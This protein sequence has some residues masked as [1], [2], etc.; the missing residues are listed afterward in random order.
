MS[1]RDKDIYPGGKPPNIERKILVLIAMV[2]GTV[3]I[4]ALGH[5]YGWW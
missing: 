3:V 5:K 4:G 1:I 2:V